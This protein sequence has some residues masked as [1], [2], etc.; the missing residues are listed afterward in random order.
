MAQIKALGVISKKFADVTPGR[1][2]QYALGVGQPKRPWASSTAASEPI[3]D[4]AMA[5][6]IQRKA[7][8]KGVRSAG[9][10][11]YLQ[12]AQ[13]KGARNFGPGVADA[14]PA[15]ERGFAKYHQ[16]IAGLTLP[17]RFGR[18]DPR[19]LQRVALIATT[20]GKLKES[21]GG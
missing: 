10:A 19:N 13:G 8:G 6:A 1:A 5:A 7:F 14:G 17:Q 11:K 3:F 16:A 4:A 9:D 2:E 12:G 15:Y 20:L 21:S 18:R